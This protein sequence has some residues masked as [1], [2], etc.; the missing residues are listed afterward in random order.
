MHNDELKMAKPEPQKFANPMHFTFSRQGH[1]TEAISCVL[2]LL[3]SFGI[4]IHASDHRLVADKYSLYAK[5]LS[6]VVSQIMFGTRWSGLGT[7]GV[8]AMILPVVCVLLVRTTSLPSPL[9]CHIM[10]F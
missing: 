2:D 6:P 5:Q 7:H 3:S 1:S 8:F 9:P 4:Y 10:R